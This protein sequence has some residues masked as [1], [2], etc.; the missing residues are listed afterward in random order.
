M[1]EKKWR[2]CFIDKTPKAL[3]LVATFCNKLKFYF[4]KVNDHLK[5]NDVISNTLFRTIKLG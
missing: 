5:A 4:P 2:E 1:H 3:E